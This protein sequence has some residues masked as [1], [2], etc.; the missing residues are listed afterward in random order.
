MSILIKYDIFVLND[1]VEQASCKISMC[2]TTNKI[3]NFIRVVLSWFLIINMYRIWARV[4]K[5]QD[6]NCPSGKKMKGELYVIPLK[7][8]HRLVH[9]R[10][11]NHGT[12]VRH[13]KILQAHIS[14]RTERLSPQK[15]NEFDTIQWTCEFRVCI[16]FSPYLATVMFVVTFEILNCLT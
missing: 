6:G 8:I 14:L 16:F 7:H 9:G 11:A 10:E 12:P 5:W 3:L 1:Y 4:A 15:S 13:I 2:Q